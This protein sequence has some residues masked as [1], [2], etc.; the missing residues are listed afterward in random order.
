MGP[1]ARGA[2]EFGVTAIRL[3]HAVGNMAASV[4]AL[5]SHG[6]PLTDLRSRTLERRTS[7]AQHAE[8]S[9]ERW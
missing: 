2:R 7:K 3:Q 8:R 4:L 9:N 6:R 1:T 5:G